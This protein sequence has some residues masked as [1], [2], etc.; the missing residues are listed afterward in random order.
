MTGVFAVRWSFALRVF[1][2]FAALITL[3]ALAAP[4]S[5]SAQQTTPKKPRLKNLHATE[6]AAKPRTP[7]RSTSSCAEFGAGFMR[8]PG[9]DTCVRIGGSVSVD[10]GGRF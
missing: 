9:S 4:Y 6:P 2:L 3:T 8:L 10:G 1:S 7:S 5:L